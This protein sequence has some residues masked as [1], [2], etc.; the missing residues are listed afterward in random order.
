MAEDGKGL[1]LRM[2]LGSN[3]ME[4][5][6]RIPPPGATSER[7]NPHP[8]ERVERFHPHD[9]NGLSMIDVRLMFEVPNPSREAADVDENT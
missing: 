4:K 9:W 5:W 8:L 1:G 6:C 2:G 7:V 3:I